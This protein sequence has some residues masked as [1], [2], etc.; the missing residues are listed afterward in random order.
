MWS[1]KRSSGSAVVDHLLKDG[2]F[3]PRAVTRD[4][5]SAASRALAARGAEV[6][7]GD[8]GDKESVKKALKGAEV[9][10]GVSLS[11]ILHS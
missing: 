8:L 7:A 9:V 1:T 10:F 4:P 11:V 3:V 2:T 5:N 6:V